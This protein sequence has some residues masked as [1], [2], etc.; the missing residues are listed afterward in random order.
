MSNND[1][2]AAAVNRTPE[3][4]VFELS[5]LTFRLAKCKDSQMHDALAAVLP[6]V[7][8]CID[9]RK[10]KVQAAAVSVVSHV[11]KRV[12]AS[13]AI[14]LPC[15]VLLDAMNAPGASPF[16]KNFSIM[17]LDL[18]L[19]NLQGLDLREL[20]PSLVTG[21]TLHTAVIQEKLLRLTIQCLPYVN[22]EISSDRITTADK[23][24]LLSPI[25][26][27]VDVAPTQSTMERM[28]DTSSPTHSSTASA[29]VNVD[30]T[31]GAGAGANS[32][33]T[34]LGNIN[35]AVSKSGSDDSSSNVELT[36]LPAQLSVLLDFFLDILLYEVPSPTQSVLTIP[37]GL[38]MAEVRRITNGAANHKDLPSKTTLRGWKSLIAEFLCRIADLVDPAHLIRQ[39]VVGSV[40]CPNVA[41]QRCLTQLKGIQHRRAGLEDAP[42]VK[43]L[44]RF[45]VHGTVSASAAI[46]QLA[47]KKSA[48][49]KKAPAASSPPSA[50]QIR[51]V[52]LLCLSTRACSVVPG[53]VEVVSTCVFHAAVSNRLKQ[54]GL[55]FLAHLFANASPKLLSVVS[56]SMFKGLHNLV[57]KMASRVAN[58]ATMK[59]GGGNAS[60][61][62]DQKMQEE[63][64]ALV[65]SLFMAVAQ[66]ARCQPKL[67]A[68]V[69]G[70]GVAVTRTLFHTMAGSEIDQRIRLAAR[71]ALAAIRNSFVTLSSEGL[72]SLSLATRS[73]LLRETMEF[74]RG[75]NDQSDSLL[76]VLVD[77]LHPSSTIFFF[78][79]NAVIPT[80]ASEAE[81]KKAK[82]AR[83]TIQMTAVFCLIW[84]CSHTGTL[85]HA[86][87]SAL[88]LDNKQGGDDLVYGAKRQESDGQNNQS[89][90]NSDKSLSDF[91]AWLR[92]LSSPNERVSLLAP[93]G[94]LPGTNRAPVTPT[95][96]LLFAAPDT[97]S[98]AVKYTAKCLSFSANKVPVTT[99]L[100]RNWDQSHAANSTSAEKRM[101][102]ENDVL[103]TNII[104]QYHD[105]LAGLLG[106]ETISSTNT[107]P[108]C[109]SPEDAAYLPVLQVSSSAIVA[110]Y[111]SC[112]EAIAMAV[113]MPTEEQIAQQSNPCETNSTQTASIIPVDYANVDHIK[114]MAQHH[115]TTV[116]SHFAGILAL[117]L[118][119]MPPSLQKETIVDLV[120][121]ARRNPDRTQRFLAAALARGTA[122]DICSHGAIVTLG[123]IVLFQKRSDSTGLLS[124]EVLAD[125]STVVLDRVT[126]WR[127]TSDA[128][129]ISHQ[130]KRA[131][132]VASL[133]TLG[134]LISTDTLCIGGET[135]TGSP[136]AVYDAALSG[137]WRVSP[138]SLEKAVKVVSKRQQG[139]QKSRQDSSKAVDQ[140]RQKKISSLETR[141]A[142]IKSIDDYDTNSALTAELNK[143]RE[144]LQ[145]SQ[146]V[147]PQPEANKTGKD[148][149]VAQS[150][151]YRSCLLDRLEV[152]AASNLEPG[153]GKD[154]EKLLLTF[155]GASSVSH[156]PSTVFHTTVAFSTGTGEPNL[157]PA[158]FVG[159][160]R[161]GGS[162]PCL[163]VT[164]EPV[165]K[166][167]DQSAGSKPPLY[168]LEGQLRGNQLVWQTI[169]LCSS[170]P[171]SSTLASLEETSD[172]I[173]DQFLTLRTP[174]VWS[175]MVWQVQDKVASDTALGTSMPEL[176]SVLVPQLTR[177]LKSSDMTIAKATISLCTRI[178]LAAHSLSNLSSS[179]VSYFSPYSTV[180]VDQLLD[181][182]RSKYEDV[183]RSVG[184]ALAATMVM[185]AAKDTELAQHSF[186]RILVRKR[187]ETSA[188]SVHID[189]RSKPK[190]S[191]LS[192]KNASVAKKIKLSSPSNVD[193]HDSAAG[194]DD[195]G[196]TK[197][198]K[199]LVPAAASESK[200][201]SE[202]SASVIL[203]HIYGL[204]T[205][206][207]MGRA[208]GMWLLEIII[209][210]KEAPN[211][212][213]L[214]PRL[215]SRQS[216]GL[217]EVETSASPG[218]D[219]MLKIQEKLLNM[220]R[221]RDI[222]CTEEAAR[223]LVLMY[224][225]VN[226]TNNDS[227]FFTTA[228]KKLLSQLTQSL[229]LGEQLKQSGSKNKGK[230][231]GKT[232]VPP[233]YRELYGLARDLGDTALIY[234]FLPAAVASTDG[235]GDADNADGS[236]SEIDMLSASSVRDAIFGAIRSQSTPDTAQTEPTNTVS[237]LK[238]AAAV[239]EE[240][241][242]SKLVPHMKG[243][244]PRLFVLRNTP[245]GRVRRAVRALWTVLVDDTPKAVA[246][247]R[248][249]ILRHCLKAMN[250]PNWM[251]RA[252]GSGAVT[253]ALSGVA[254]EEVVFMQTRTEEGIISENTDFLE[255]LN[256]EGDRT[257][258]A[259]QEA[260]D[261]D[262]SSTTASSDNSRA[263]YLLLLWQTVLRS[264]DDARK[265]S[266]AVGTVAALAVK[267][268]IERAANRKATSA[269]VCQF[270]VDHIIPYLMEKGIYNIAKEARY[271]SIDL[272]RNVVRECGDCVAPHAVSLA[273]GLLESL[274]SLESSRLVYLQ[275][276]THTDRLSHV[277][278]A[279]S[280]VESIRL[281]VAKQSP[282]QE[283]LDVVLKYFGPRQF[284][285]AVP[286]LAVV[287]KRGVGLATR[288]ASAAFVQSCMD[289]LE[290]ADTKPHAQTILKALEGGVRDHQSAAVRK[291]YARA[292]ASTIRRAKTGTT[293]KFLAFIV[294]WAWNGDQAGEHSTGPISS[295]SGNNAEAEHAGEVLHQI[296]RYAA[297]ASKRFQG[298]F[299]PVAFVMR[300][301]AGSVGDKKRGAAASNADR[302]ESWNAVWELCVP[303]TAAGVRLFQAE[304]VT[305]GIIPSLSS[306]R[307]DI[308]QKAGLATQELADTLSA[309][310]LEQ[311]AEVLLKELDTA[312]QSSRGLWSGKEDLVL[313]YSSILQ[314]S[315]ATA[316]KKEEIE[317]FSKLLANEARKASR[318]GALEY[319]V[320]EGFSGSKQGNKT[321]VLDS[322]GSSDPQ[323]ARYIRHIFSCFNG[324]STAF[325]DQ[326]FWP[327]ARKIVQ[328]VVST[329][330]TTTTSSIPPVLQVR[331]LECMAHCWDNCSV[332][333]VPTLNEDTK[334]CSDAALRGPWSVTVAALKAFQRVI[335]KLPN[336]F[337]GELGQSEATANFEG[338]LAALS[339]LDVALA[340][341]KYSKVRVA[342]ISAACAFV[343]ASKAAT[344][345]LSITSFVA[346]K[347]AELERVVRSLKKDGVPAVA[348]AATRA[349]EGLEKQE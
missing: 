152:P 201:L 125:I 199:T 234:E 99:F 245:D 85:R 172:W 346:D 189:I 289:K 64:I 102:I 342:A 4:E 107:T 121:A 37:K 208:V 147:E 175:K 91:G 88:S 80:D 69:N 291:A 7:L 302:D 25:F 68:G 168:L 142:E 131:L 11:M 74:L 84:L 93:V 114:F 228:R 236:S 226:P 343:E 29:D 171:G 30:E 144:E 20:F 305:K 146:K 193:A 1:G 13:K 250:D 255:V 335:L 78:P 283:T 265:E 296:V 76:E 155:G 213:E 133:T 40:L 47:S 127:V 206:A 205:E 212:A 196:I 158:L 210:L 100:R 297:K 274:S 230:W 141:I 17:L 42:L 79:A 277:E 294:D 156:D 276:Q 118:R 10:P 263:M 202:Y 315:E 54:V 185:L 207:K 178:L 239:S 319:A 332:D 26:D 41:A 220:L 73:A 322:A 248:D 272:L 157:R 71:G 314:N 138:A 28:R 320:K 180:L 174:S 128:A 129:A 240:I 219:A 109:Y 270:T 116:R 159:R 149:N 225:Q 183:Q 117:L 112:P 18:G 151:D 284:K 311:H 173:G 290:T 181:R 280:K 15:K 303:S 195:E 108:R 136:H 139:A 278:D 86:V 231:A 313:A 223:G 179:A 211:A 170:A 9:P 160:S 143:L 292:A 233:V 72:N 36:P 111:R 295:G 124:A 82:E 106:I 27:Y 349:V 22:N 288:V 345:K 301:K 67:F 321:I 33:S 256:F 166:S 101:R 21:L 165:T 23:Q 184:R 97:I 217:Q 254:A 31:S 65:E 51:L 161:C 35:T 167:V 304:I 237:S 66:L 340:S 271:L 214:W 300:Q 348:A 60:V 227:K 44:M 2:S 81:T 285:D 224:R 238:I 8:G 244:V 318:N 229:N 347:T 5:K 327:V 104:E 221:H 38:S 126:H 154:F 50:V 269:S 215:S 324:L 190:D 113:S 164:I 251:K 49:S 135:A 339:A 70:E 299:V 150:V 75:S 57:K 140:S 87:L 338:V 204:P 103:A 52:E 182:C 307:W 95:N 273:C 63:M 55:K 14:K 123:Q 281:Q 341:Q 329:N 261:G 344:Q 98:V 83:D 266:R 253:E 209:A 222:M 232:T 198:A 169:A 61:V 58:T 249:A 333:D 262:E 336:T 310:A 92:F 306:A 192:T 12:K 264:V 259:S 293:K 19:P 110:L 241:D 56:P 137:Q 24:K 279:E 317:Q 334:M 132:V 32:T 246:D 194:K 145:I 282:M 163:Y 39:F 43:E 203:D 105:F 328:R 16:T 235:I 242:R 200:C 258:T 77:W 48:K 218:L 115:D 59:V 287:L 316:A 252:A 275:Q 46:S 89:R 257:R 45:C 53:C 337:F 312:L 3:Q 34:S 134:A 176:M 94:S 153:L 187:G 162:I 260:G 148:G 247:H 197:A 308:K 90:C 186:A 6:T 96:V 191:A 326:N 268:F 267:K 130:R 62:A 286:K 243:L 298:E 309:S 330:S 120:N 119:A 216:L 122:L 177:M 323:S 331:G 188:G 325:A